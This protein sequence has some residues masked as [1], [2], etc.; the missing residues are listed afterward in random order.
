M[1]FIRI[2]GGLLDRICVLTGAFVGS[3]VP[4]FMQQYSQRLSGHI[5]EL[6]YQ[7]QSWR[8]MAG[9]SG[10][11]LQDY[12]HKFSLNPDA[13][14]SRHGEHMQSM[15]HRMNEMTQSYQLIHDSTTWSRPFVFASHL[16]G[17]IF[18][19]TLHTFVPQM[20]LT[21]DGALYTLLGLVVGY[22]TFHALR[23]LCLRGVGFSLRSF[24]G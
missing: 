21:L 11:S 5:H 14:F 1:P 7:I 2:I 16:N 19:S 12:I 8:Q 20:T 15:M 23:A 10:K 3:Q 18:R 13:D 17:E 24:K 22:A 6:Q 9:L 4:S